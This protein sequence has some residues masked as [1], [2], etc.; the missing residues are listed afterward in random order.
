MLFFRGGFVFVACQGFGFMT[1]GFIP[2]LLKPLTLPEP[3]SG[4]GIHKAVG[5]QLHLVPFTV[6]MVA[7]RQE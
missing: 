3:P 4:G 7:A 6:M 2:M 1:S 5:G